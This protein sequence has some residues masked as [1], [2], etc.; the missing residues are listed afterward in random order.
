MPTKKK[1]EAAETRNEET[2]AGEM[3]D[4]P[5]TSGGAVAK[6]VEQ[7]ETL[8]VLELSDLVKALETRFGVTAA[9][10]MAFMPGMMAGGAATAAAEEEKTEF[11]A[12]LKEFG[13]NKIQVIKVVRA[14]TGLGL[15]EAKKLVED[16]PK[17]IKE[18][19]N[20]AEAEDI[21]KKVEEVGGAVEIK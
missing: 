2:A 18:A 8:T 6:I 12:M 3:H 13:A 21:K 14:I 9:A 11:T 16:A 19:V 5:K 15:I 1:D 20:K 7:V 17:A 10:P 4:T